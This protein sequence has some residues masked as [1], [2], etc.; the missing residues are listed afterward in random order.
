MKYALYFI[1]SIVLFLSCN[2]QTIGIDKTNDLVMREE[3]SH[4]YVYKNKYTVSEIY[5]YRGGE[6]P[7]REVI[8]EK[9]AQKYIIPSFNVFNL[10]EVKIDFNKM[11]LY[12]IK[13]VS[14][15]NKN[16]SI[17]NDTLYHVE[18]GKREVSGIVE[19]DKS[20]YSYFKTYYY[21]RFQNEKI[22]LENSGSVSEILTQK[23]AFQKANLSFKNTEYGFNS[24][25]DMK[26]KNDVVC[27]VVV[28]FT[29][30]R[31]DP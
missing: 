31:N 21:Y 4:S 26:N 6:N 19:L 14:K 27:W 7:A 10:D 25:A 20:R 3:E 28:S 11:Q 29:L 24:L 9:E 12:E 22:K 1:G 13:G 5:F 23:D 17:T 2:K 16:I 30:E 15:T 18:N 8:T